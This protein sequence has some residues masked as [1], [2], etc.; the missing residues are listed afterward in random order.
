MKIF[1]FL[2][3]LFFPTTI[4]A[5][6]I[7]NDVS[8]LNPTSVREID[9]PTTTEEIKKKVLEARRLNLKI[10]IAGKR[11][12]Q[13]GQQSYSNCIVLDMLSY[14]KILFL[15]VKKRIIRVQSGVTWDQIQRHINPFNLSLKVMQ[16]S[17]IFTVGGSVS[18]NVHGMDFRYGN[19]RNVI[20]SFRLLLSDGRVIN[21]NRE[22]NSELFDLVIGGLGLFGVILDVDIELIGNDV[23]EQKTEVMNYKEYVNDYR[24]NIHSDPKVQFHYAMLSVASDNNFLKEMITTSYKKSTKRLINF[25]L[26]EE[27][28]IFRDKLFLGLSRKCSWGKSLRWYLQ[29]ILRNGSSDENVISRNN[30]MRNPVKFL[31]YSSAKDT[32]ILQEYFVPLNKFVEFVDGLREI[33]KHEKINL[34]YVGVRHVPADSGQYIS[35]AKEDS[36]ALVL[37]INQGLSEED[38][39]A[40]RLWT[41]K[42]VDLALTCKGKY[43]LVYQLYPTFKQLQ[44]AYPNIEKFFRMKKFY[45]PQEIFMNKFYETY[46]PGKRS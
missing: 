4:Q 11:H 20:K 17:N 1:L 26:R 40:A 46:T 21:V 39:E 23:Y 13:G 16:T 45:D 9:H 35:Y 44:T 42:L 36:I 2:I 41:R 32:D 27:E 33:V 8:R 5:N 24:E 28:N 3:V 12:S 30:I 14:N 38:K 34:L 6:V 43:Y 25:D 29:K 37:Y 31:E 22:E 7:F 18:A 15:D 19:I 10:S